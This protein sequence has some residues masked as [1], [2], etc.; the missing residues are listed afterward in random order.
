MGRKTFESLPNSKPLPNRYHIVVT[1]SYDYAAEGAHI[2]SS[3]ENAIK[4]AQERVSNYPPEVFIIGGGEIYRQTINRVDTIYLTRINKDFDGDTLYPS[5]PDDF[6]LV[7][8]IKHE[9]PVPFS[10]LTYKK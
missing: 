3:I 1:R 4:F 7:E 9:E 2:A 10:F 6:K 5:M 8:E